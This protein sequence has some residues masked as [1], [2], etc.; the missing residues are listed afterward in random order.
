MALAPQLLPCDGCGQLADPLHIA[1]RLQ[2]LEWATR[3]RPVHIQ[4]LLVSG[5]AP[6]GDHEYLYNPDGKFAG[7]AG[8]ILSAVQMASQGKNVEAVLS[9]FQK[10]G[11]ML[12]HVL[13]CPLSAGSSASEARS[14]LEKQLAP[15]VTRI[16]RSLKPKRIILISPDLVPVAE[17][18]QHTEMGCP[19]YPTA[20]V[21]LSGAAPASD[22]L[23][24]FRNVL[25]ATHAQP[26]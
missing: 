5:I 26:A 7:E 18:L 13:E 11:L 25:G 16:R 2:R 14:L 17:S 20:G 6:T 12:I 21:F 3:Y 23:Q 24:S 19:V 15:T 22:E 4:A 8:R 10:L 9:E 1:R